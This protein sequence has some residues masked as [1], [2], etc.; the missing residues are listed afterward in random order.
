MTDWC[1][2]LAQQIVAQSPSNT[3]KIVANADDPVS[4]V[5]SA[6]AS[7]LTKCHCSVL[8]VRKNSVQQHQEKFE[9][10]PEDL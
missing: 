9:N 2:D 6:D 8:E 10:L 5:P 7:N 1:H 4:H 3:V